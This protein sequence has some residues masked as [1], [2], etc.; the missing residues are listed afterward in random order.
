MPSKDEFDQYDAD[1]DEVEGEVLEPEVDGTDE[2]AAAR[3]LVAAS[4]AK[5][6]SKPNRAQRR[7]KSNHPRPA[8]APEPQDHLPK[9]SIRAREMD[10]DD[11][12]VLTLFDREYRVRRGDLADSWDYMA[13]MA[14]DNMPKAMMCVIGAQGFARFS[15]DA[16]ANGVNPREGLQMFWDAFGDELGMTAGNS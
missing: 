12:L 3:E 2:L 1:F 4:D 10:E 6:R 14:S 7:S 8:G 9:K 13:A 5:R 16:K 15:A 11:V